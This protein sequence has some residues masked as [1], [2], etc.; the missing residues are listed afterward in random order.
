MGVYVDGQ[1]V[2]VVVDKS[3][4]LSEA[5]ATAS[6]ILEGKT[7]YTGEGKVEGT[8]K[9]MLQA[10][11]DE[12]NSCAYLFYN[13][14][15]D[16]SKFLK[17]LDT[18]NSTTFQSMLGNN[19]NLIEI[20]PLDTRKGEHFEN[21][22]NGSNKLETI[23]LVDLRSTKYS[24]SGTFSF[25]PNIKN[26]TIKNITLTSID[27]GSGTY[28][29]HLLTLDS[30]LNTIKELWENTG[31]YSIKLTMGSA[32]VEKLNNVYVKLVEITEQMR[33]EDEYI[34][35]KYPF[36]VCESADDGSMSIFDYITK[37]KKWNYA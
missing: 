8:Y 32:N 27:I 36:V 20:P 24:L 16:A 29:G 37:I 18:S 25:L 12:T 28:W 23:S 5:T 31:G 9:D 2:G 4:D 7:A 22:F 6:D 26:L 17:K 21:A 14:T 1:E 30:L 10:R 11:I 15:G 19:D 33:K 35:K 3:L 13:Y 34:D